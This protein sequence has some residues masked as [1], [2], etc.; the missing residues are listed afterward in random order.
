[1]FRKLS[2]N[3]LVN[4][5]W[6]ILARDIDNKALCEKVKA[7]VLNKWITIRGNAFVK[8]WVDSMKI[9]QSELKSSKSTVDTKAMPAMRKTLAGSKK[10]KKTD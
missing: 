3:G 2:S 9:R 10:S 5:G 1:M 7:M 4:T 8:S 6:D